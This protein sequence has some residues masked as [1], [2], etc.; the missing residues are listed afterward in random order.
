MHR[1]PSLLALPHSICFVSCVCLCWSVFHFKG[2]CKCLLSLGRPLTQTT[3]HRKA[4]GNGEDG[5]WTRR[6][7]V[8]FHTDL[9]SLTRKCLPGGILQSSGYSLPLHP[10]A[11][12]KDPAMPVTPKAKAS[13]PSGFTLAFGWRDDAAAGWEGSLL[14]ATTAYKNFPPNLFSAQFSMPPQNVPEPLM[15]ESAR[16]WETGSCALPLGCPLCR[17]SNLDTNPPAASD[18]HLQLLCWPFAHSLCSRALP[19][20]F[21]LYCHLSG[22][23]TSAFSSIFR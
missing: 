22:I 9:S 6:P 5:C 1:P 15:P 7:K 17:S 14:E 21:I 18:S 12:G 16:G 8:S 2:I 11:C 20:G 19:Q 23:K 13:S 4:D 3:S 10:P